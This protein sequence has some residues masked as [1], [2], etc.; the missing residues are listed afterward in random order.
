MKRSGV[1]ASSDLWKAENIFYPTAIREATSSS[2]V[3][4]GDRLEEGV[5]QS[6]GLQVS[7]SPGKML[8]EGEFQDVIKTSQHTDPEAPK[9][10]AEPVVGSQMS[11][12]EEPATL[13]QP[14]QAIPTSVVPQSADIDPVQPS[15]EGA[16]L[17]D[18]KTDSAS[19]S[20]DV[21]GAKLKS[22]NLG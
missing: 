15:L 5:T 16:I 2:S 4:M 22:R 14:P 13:A 10:V 8:K 3:A 11:S 19:P 6:E 7:G 12:A 18:A 20:L 17:Q 9:E 1:D 21:A